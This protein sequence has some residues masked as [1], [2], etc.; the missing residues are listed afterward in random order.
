MPSFEILIAFLLATSVFS[1]MPGPSTLYAAAQTIARG[2]RGGL[3]AERI[4]G[5]LRRSPASG[6]WANRLGGGILVTLGIHLA[7]TR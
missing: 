1:Y 7:I 5:A 4:T 2:R 6:R 3:L